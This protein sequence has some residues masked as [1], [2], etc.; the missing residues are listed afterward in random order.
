M[1]EK[2]VKNKLLIFGYGYTARHLAEHVKSLGWQIKGTSRSRD[3]YNPDV[4]VYDELLLL[5]PDITHIIISIPPRDGQDI[6]CERFYN[7]I[8]KL[9]K[10]EYIGYLSSTGVYGDQKGEWVDEKSPPSIESEFSRCRLNAE[11]AWC[12]LARELKIRCCTFRLAGIYGPGRSAVDSLL[13]GSARI[14]DC[15]NIF[16]R[17]HVQDICKVILCTLMDKD[18][19]G[20]F[21]VADDFP[22][23]Q[24]EVMDY[25]CELLNLRKLK[26]VSIEDAGLSDFGKYI[27]SQQK[28][29]L[30]TKIKKNFG[31]LLFP[32]Y[33][34]GLENI[35]SSIKL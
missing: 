17:V 3:L 26:P 8:V 27:Y 16:S 11:N 18:A 34:K 12:R 24:K 33:K 13:K 4:I 9:K 32:T 7:Q 23:S 15:P 19:K 2:K 25:A 35:A 30:N 14:V 10:L 21:N 6:V 20:I 1:F 29:V 28:R 5:D 31:D 22:C